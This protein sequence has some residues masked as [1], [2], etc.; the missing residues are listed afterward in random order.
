MNHKYYLHLLFSLVI[1]S[2]G[3]PEF[4]KIEEVKNEYKFNTAANLLIDAHV[5]TIDSLYDSGVEGYFFGADS[6][7]I[8]Y[9]YFTQTEAEKGAIV[10]SSGR[11]EAAIKYK[12]VIFDLYNHGYSVYIHDHRGQGFSGRMLPDSDMGYV[13]DFQFYINDLKQFYETIVYPRKRKNCFLLAHSM[14]GAIGVTYLEQF[15]DDFTAAAFTSPMLGLSFP[16]CPVVSL[17]KDTVPKYALGNSGYDEGL[18]GFKKNTLTSSKIR[19]ERM[20]RVFDEFPK[21]RLGGATYQWVIKSCVQFDS[22]FANIPRIKTPLILFSGSNEKIVDPKAHNNFV[23]QL[24]SLNIDA[25]GFLVEGA[26]H[27]ML[28]ETDEIRVEVLTKIL[29]FYTKFEEG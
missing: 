17:V 24:D 22:I 29:D 16:S 14:G 19:Y 9:K 13:D 23:Y 12:E 1:I 4:E 10:I 28:I 7:K 11:T 2:C 15:P 27:E 20:N 3:Q 26:K 5:K 25:T 18:M 21:A 8:Y 6:L